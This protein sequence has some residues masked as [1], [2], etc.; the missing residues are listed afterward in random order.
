MMTRQFG[1]AGDAVEVLER[2]LREGARTA[3]VCGLLAGTIESESLVVARVAMP[4][5]NVSTRGNSFAI[6]PR[7]LRRAR[8]ALRADG[9]AVL[10]LYH[11]HPY[12]STRPSSRDLQLPTITGLLAV[13]VATSDDRVL[14]A[15]Y[16]DQRG[17]VRP[18]E[19]LAP[20]R[21]VWARD[22]P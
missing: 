20:Y 16:G 22:A 5:R 6:D 10:A 8:T 12:G 11:S 21:P 13:I 3:E 19:V 4:L 14:A 15:C 9:Y 2:Q 7:V 18:I 1:I 17:R